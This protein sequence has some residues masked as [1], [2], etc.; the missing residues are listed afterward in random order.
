M[1]SDLKKQIEEDRN[2]AR[3]SGDGFVRDTLS[4]V[5]SDIRNREIETGEEAD[6]DEVRS[7]LASAVK[8]REEAA[9]QM[10]EG[11]RPEL[12]DKEEREAELLSDYLPP[13]L[14]EDEVREMV[15]DAIAQGADRVGPIMGRIMPRIR[16]RFDGKEANRIVQEELEGQ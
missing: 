8:Q 5:L 4:M 14:E 10:R 6:D 11:D 16:G 9:G 15:R 13:P 1:P 12:A 2:E 3:R 7:V